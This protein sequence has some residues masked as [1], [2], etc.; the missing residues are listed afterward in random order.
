MQTNLMRIALSMSELPY[1]SDDE[2][3]VFRITNIV[4]FEII[5]DSFDELE[6]TY[7]MLNKITCMDIVRIKNYIIS[8]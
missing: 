6:E 2:L 7:D 3:G 4:K 1:D 8:P 5:I